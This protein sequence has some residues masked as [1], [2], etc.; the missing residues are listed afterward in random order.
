MAY[1][2]V[3][4][5]G[6]SE[7]PLVIVFW[8]PLLAIPLCLPLVAARPLLPTGLEALWLLG[9]GIFTQVGQ[10]CLTQGL[11]QLP[12]ARSTA[13]GYSQVLF[14]ALWGGLFFGEQ[15]DGWTALGAL[16][17]LAAALIRP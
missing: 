1:V 15:P 13:I 11:T 16:L 4:A 10:V 3:R 7:H 6:R 17:I 2:S 14:A 12:V 9:V 8:F 5:L